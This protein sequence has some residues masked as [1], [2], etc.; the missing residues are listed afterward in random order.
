MSSPKRA[1]VVF[2][3]GGIE[4]IEA[5]DAI[6]A[7]DAI[8]DIEDMGFGCCGLGGMEKNKKS[9]SPKKNCACSKQ[10]RIVCIKGRH[11]PTYGFLPQ[12]TLRGSLLSVSLAPSCAS[13]FAFA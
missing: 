4:D 6:D 2:F 1:V 13:G 12:P 5:I 8:E 11:G 3:W 10:W 9:A 7:I